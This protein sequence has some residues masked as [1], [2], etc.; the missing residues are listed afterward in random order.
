MMTFV[1]KGQLQSLIILVWY[2]SIKRRGDNLFCMSAL[3]CD[4][5]SPLLFLSS[6]SFER[7]LIKMLWTMV[8][9]SSAYYSLIK[10]WRKSELR[11]ELQKILPHDSVEILINA[12][13]VRWT[14]IYSPHALISGNACFNMFCARCLNLRWIIHE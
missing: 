13:C 5:P 9:V 12:A 6:S 2:L 8:V 11:C 14:N 1:W 10:Y 7:W 4:L 3:Q